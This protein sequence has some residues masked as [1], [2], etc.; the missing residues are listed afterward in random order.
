M[1]DSPP[2]KRRLR[3]A[4]VAPLWT[5]V[6]PATYGGIELLVSLLTDE[7]VRRGHEVT[8][9]GTGDSRTSGTLRAVCDENVLD[10]MSAGKIANYE[11]YGN[12]A[13]TEALLA[14]DQFD[15]IH[16]HIGCEHIPSGALSG[17]PV[18]FTMH[19]QPGVDDSWV[20]RKYPRVPVAGISRFQ[21]QALE[22]PE[23]KDIP[24]VY[25][26]CDFSTFDPAYE[27][28][29]YLVFLGRLSYDKNPLD[30]I[31]IAKEV[32]MPLI[33]AGNAQGKKETAYFESE[34]E[35]LIND[36]DIKYIGL[37]NHAQKNKLLREA[38]A[39][40]VPVQWNEPFG[41]VMIEAM[42]CGTPVVAHNLG[43]ISEVVDQG[44]TGFHANS[45]N[46]MAALVPRAI[47]LPRQTVR[48]QAEKRFSYQRMVDDY[49]DIYNS[50]QQSR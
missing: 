36:E 8:L 13:V 39:M 12:A 24:V 29:S 4:Q 9:F 5:K 19:T 11:Y 23:R 41:L 22:I 10:G 42:A 16:F 35:P 49:L 21:V 18:L 2:Q 50:L 37:V 7:L 46:A 1:T 32:G 20:L 25:N 26:G 14:A 30:A 17:T 6:P 43:S 33:L 28:G 27:P 15:V 45:I 48:S 47:A 40:L 31:R 3:I 34:I 38:A 44:I